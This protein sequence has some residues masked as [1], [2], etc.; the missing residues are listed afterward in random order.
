MA[1]S[2]TRTTGFQARHRLWVA[3][4]SDQENRRRF[5][6][7]TEPHPHDYRCSV[8]VS[9]PTDPHGMVIDLAHLD[10]ILEAEVRTPLDGRQLDRDLPDFA[11]GTPLATCE[12]LAEYLYRRIR[13]RLPAGVVLARVRVAE[14]DTLSAECTGTV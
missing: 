2:L 8:T 11:A 4:W 10:R 3:G 5:G 6:P 13:P 7:L 1:T 9:G 12:A 14:D